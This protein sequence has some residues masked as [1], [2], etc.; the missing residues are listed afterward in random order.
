[1]AGNVLLIHG[2]W[3]RSLSM[4]WLATRLRSQGF[5]P[6]QFGYFSLL[7]DTDAVVTRLAAVLRAQPGMHVLAHSLGG[8][9]A[10]RAAALAGVEQVGR[11]VCLGS[12]LAGSQAASSLIDTLPAGAQLVG[13][14]R[15]LLLAGIERVPDGLA[16]GMIAG[17]KPRGLGGLMTRWSGPHDG[18][19]AVAE[20]QVP[21]LRGHQVLDASHSGLLF[22]D[23]ALR[24]SAGFFRDGYFERA[25]APADV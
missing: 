20:T 7:Q 8:L 1:M 5:T 9:L 16:L 21:G 3:M 10:V 15:Q 6:H 4:R 12:P 14:N 24:L 17:A 2:L 22:S 11:V 13:R 19:V 18:T 25:T 23:A